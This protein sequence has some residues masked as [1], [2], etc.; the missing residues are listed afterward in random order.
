M[1]LTF[2][3]DRLEEGVERQRYRAGGRTAD[4]RS[5]AGYQKQIAG[6]NDKNKVVLFE[7]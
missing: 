1:L 6:W 4:Q 7:A 2:R 3:H 5:A